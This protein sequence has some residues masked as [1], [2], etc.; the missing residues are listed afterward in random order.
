MAFAITT[1]ADAEPLTVSEVK[2]Q[3][4]WPQTDNTWDI[5]IQSAIAAARQYAEIYTQ[6]VFVTSTVTQVVDRFPGSRAALALLPNAYQIGDAIG[7]PFLPNGGILLEVA[8]VQSVT[9]IEY[10]DTTG[11]LL[12]VDP[13][14]YVADLIT[15]P[16]RITP[17]FGQS[18][19]VAQSQIAAVKLTYIAGYGEPKD[20]PEGLKVWMKMRIAALWQNREEVVVGSR[21]TVGELPFVDAMLDAFRIPRF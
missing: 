7:N 16:A 8:P 15:E 2:Y 4:P 3:L 19:P 21:L 13:A 6:K 1:A 10:T 18:W 12:T 11:A 20:V 14:T 9:K 5:W 17:L